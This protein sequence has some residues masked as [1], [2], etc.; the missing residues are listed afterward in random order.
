MPRLRHGRQEPSDEGV[1]TAGGNID[2]RKVFVFAQDFTV[3]GGS[4]GEMSRQEDLQG[5]GSRG[6]VGA[7]LIGINDSGGARIQRA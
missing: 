1:V 3:M 6:K 4:L 5:H 2:G 7:P